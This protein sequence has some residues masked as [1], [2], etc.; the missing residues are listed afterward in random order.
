MNHIFRLARTWFAIAVAVI[1]GLF[2]WA[3]QSRE[4]ADGSGEFRAVC[5][6]RGGTLV[7]TIDG[8]LECHSRD[9]AE[10]T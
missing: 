3:M 6:Y 10:Q 9:A 2:V 5:A 1:S 8:H 4:P 7:T